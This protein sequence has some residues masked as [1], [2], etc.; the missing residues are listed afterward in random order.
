VTAPKIAIVWRGDRDER[1]NATPTNNRF[2][3]MFEELAAVGIDAEPAVYDAFQPLRAKIEK[4]WAPQMLETL[5]LPRGSM[6][7]IWDAD[8]LFGSRD[9]TSADT[10]CCAKS[11]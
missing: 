10:M 11:M 1:R 5:G 7:V 6:P 4:E 9:A 8:F 2:H 3:R